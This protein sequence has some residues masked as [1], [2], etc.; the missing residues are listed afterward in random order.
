MRGFIMKKHFISA[1]LALI[2]LLCVPLSASAHPVPDMTR[3]GSITV[4]MTYQNKPVPGGSL[5]LY[6]VGNVHE[7]DGNY[8]FKPVDALDDLISEFGDIQSPELAGT[9][10][11]YAAQKKL[12]SK[13]AAI[14]QNGTA[15][16]S[17]LQLGLYLVVQDTAASGYEKTTPFLVS[18]PYLDD[19]TYV[20]DVQS[21]PKTELEREVKPT[22]PTTP[23]SSSGSGGKLAQT[24]QL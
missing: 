4:S 3:K 23:H 22:T 12:G 1:F 21:D 18:V 2:L 9:L 24:G 17:E 20:Y 13:S 15:V 7:D 19:G 6:R 11:G 5:K 10:T 16:F 14:G 8:S